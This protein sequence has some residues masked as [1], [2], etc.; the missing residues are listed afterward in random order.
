MAAHATI[1]QA[2]EGRVMFP[3]IQFVFLAVV[4]LTPAVWFASWLD[5]APV[6]EEF[7]DDV[8]VLD[9]RDRPTG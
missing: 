3:T 6:V 7:A 1:R 5:R 4:V 8:S 9:L 2:D